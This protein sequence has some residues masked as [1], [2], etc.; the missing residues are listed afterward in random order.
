MR[1]K[2][3]GPTLMTT[4]AKEAVD[5]YATH[6]DAAVNDYG[7]AEAGK[8]C[9]YWTLTFGEKAADLSFQTPPAGEAPFAGAGLYFYVELDDAAAVDAQRTRLLEAGIEVGSTSTAHDMYQCWLRDPAGLQLM[10][11]AAV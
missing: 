1:I 9:W 3:A 10:V 6:F 4:K 5:F 2:T 7:A 8:D 11:Y